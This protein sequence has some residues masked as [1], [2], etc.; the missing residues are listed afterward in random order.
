ME[1][2]HVFYCKMYSQLRTHKNTN[3][4]VYLIALQETFFNPRR[5]RSSDPQSWTEQ[6]KRYPSPPPPARINGEQA[7][8]PKTHHFYI[9]EMG[10]GVSSLCSANLSGLLGSP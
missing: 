8:Q 4:S 1:D 7:L 6:N 3:Y 5:W 9:I 2:L 10:G